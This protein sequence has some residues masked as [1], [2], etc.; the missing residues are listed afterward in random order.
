LSLIAEGT[1]L[2]YQICFNGGL[3]FFDPPPMS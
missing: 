3:S 2:I 1:I